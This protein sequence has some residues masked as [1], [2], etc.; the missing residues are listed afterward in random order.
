MPCILLIL[1]VYIDLTNW[2]SKKT[3]IHSQILLND[4]VV[5]FLF[6]LF[7]YHVGISQNY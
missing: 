7:S 6:N 4:L 2:I 1:L 5:K 3:I